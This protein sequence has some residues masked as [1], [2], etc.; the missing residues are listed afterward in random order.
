MAVDRG[1][2]VGAREA[3]FMLN[4]GVR[5]EREKGVVERAWSYWSFGD[6]DATRV[7]SDR[8]AVGG[9]GLVERLPYPPFS[10]PT[11]ARFRLSWSLSISPVLAV[12]R[13]VP[14][15]SG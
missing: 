6:A 13:L 2:M 9:L 10:S 8:A 5:P 12:L 3:R 14:P 1:M 4:S 11:A 7:C 15:P